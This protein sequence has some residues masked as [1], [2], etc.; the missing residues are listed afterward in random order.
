RAELGLDAAGLNRVFRAGY[1]R[2]I[3]QTSCSAGVIEVRA[4]TLPVGATAP[5]AAGMIHSDFD[6]GFIRALTFA[7]EDFIAYKVEQ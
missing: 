3:L 6:K 4:L 5:Q 1:S 2:L 7:Y